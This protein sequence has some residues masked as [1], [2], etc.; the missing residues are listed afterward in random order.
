VPSAVVAYDAARPET[1]DAVVVD[2]A[3]RVGDLDVVILAV[4][5][6]GEQERLRDDPGAAAA[7]IAVNHAGAAASA[8]A[9]ASQFRRQG[10]G[11]LV[12]LSS[13]AGERARRGNYVYGASKAGLDAFAQGLADDLA[14]TGARVLIVRPGW[15]HGTMTAGRRPMPLATT[16]EQVARRTVRALRSGRRIVWAPAVMHPLFMVLRHLP[17]PLWRRLPQ[18]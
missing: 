11:R 5:Q 10:H 16:P 13:V 18:G 3:R 9:V 1:H 17:A 7:L 8:L 4:G 15:V 2:L 14:G 12:V 6:L